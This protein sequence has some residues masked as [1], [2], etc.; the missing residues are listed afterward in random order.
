MRIV[1]DEMRCDGHGTCVDAC[2]EVFALG[3]EDDVVTVLDEHPPEALRDSVVK[4]VRVC[5]K[6]AIAIEG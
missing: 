2:P 1:L 4:A 3:D 5:P 6:A